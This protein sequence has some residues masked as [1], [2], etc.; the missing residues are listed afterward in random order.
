MSDAPTPSK[1]GLFWSFALIGAMGFGGVLPW[2]RYMLVTRRGWLN[3]AGFTE[4]ITLAQFFPGPNV[5]NCGVIYGRRTQG[6]WGAALAVAGLYLAPAIT[7]I[8][9]G[10]LI[11]RYWA[12]PAVQ[13]IFGAVMPV[14]SGLML[15]TTLR[16]TKGMP[17]YLS[18]WIMLAVT[19][20]L[21][22]V[23]KLPLWAVILIALPL[24]L[25][26]SLRARRHVA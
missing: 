17:A 11:R 19:F 2:A 15:G 8:I 14:A 1:A 6:P 16:L 26:A 18:A 24:S 4:L 7:T 21:M 25:A 23:A 10:L 20:T 5:G 12:D 3:E 9:A 22:D 13:Q